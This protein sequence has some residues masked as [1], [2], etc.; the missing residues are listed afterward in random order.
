MAACGCTMRHERK[1]QAFWP[2]V[3]GVAVLLLVTVFASVL[4]GSSPAG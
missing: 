4:T 3:I 2:W 1:D